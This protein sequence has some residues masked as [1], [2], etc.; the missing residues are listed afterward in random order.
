[1][2]IQLRH[3]TISLINHNKNNL[4]LFFTGP[5]LRR[6]TPDNIVFWWVSPHPIN[7]AI[8]LWTDTTNRENHPQQE[9]PFTNQNLTTF[10]V[11][12]RAYIH[13][14]NVHLTEAL[15]TGTAIEYDFKLQLPDETSSSITETQLSDYLPEIRYPGQKR[16]SFV[17]QPHV[18]SILHGSCRNPHHDS[19]DSLLAADKHV[20]DSINNQTERP[21]ML[22]MTGDQV[23]V[24]HVA[25]ATLQVIHRVIDLLGLHNETFEQTQISQ[26]SDLL[27]TEEWLFR[28]EELLPVIS[29]R[30]G[31][32][33]RIQ[34]QPVF[35]SRYAHNHLISFAEVIAMYLLVWSPTLWELAGD[36]DDLSAHVPEALRQDY[37][38]EA[39]AMLNFVDGLSQVRRLMAHVPNYMIFDDHDITD[40]WNLTAQ[41]EQAAYGH[42]FSR[43]IIG[44]ALIGYF[45]CQAIGNNPDEFDPALLQHMQDWCHQPDTVR[46]DE[47]VTRMLAYQGWHFELPTTPKIVVLDT[48][49]RRWRSEIDLGQP[50]GLMDWEALCEMQQDLI[51]QQAVI[52]VSPAPIFGVKLIETIQKVVT[53]AGFPLAVDAENWM[54]HRG[55]AYTLLQI[56]K[57]VKTPRNFV[58]LSGDVHYSFAY[59]AEIRFRDNSPRIW[60]ITCSGIK[61]EF[62][63]TLLRVFDRLNRWMYGPWSP[64]N[65]FT[66]RRRMKIKQRVPHGGTR[67]DIHGRLLNTS[68]IGLVEIAPDG[69]PES[70]Q[71]LHNDGSVTQFIPRG[72]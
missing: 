15:P 69:Q 36:P 28:R 43:R 58:I 30:T 29:V 60:Q 24:D 42:P 56:F 20:E 4:P 48:R 57:H 18:H 22:L 67:G 47:L 65:L 50:S 2:R 41:W 5:V 1:M 13:L 64:L 39:K 38:D 40:D 49:T 52:L 54:A 19:E 72:D 61:N 70:I 25:G 59:D 44:N 71:E 31:V 14:L 62:P 6:T 21:A 46:H 68:G 32:L 33:R 51:D 12:E 8:Q 66:K 10:K 9:F 53:M 7:G 11:G 35:S 55:A 27:N 3:G 23:Y 26:G 37:Q 34:R 63:N 16:P 45:L 17:V